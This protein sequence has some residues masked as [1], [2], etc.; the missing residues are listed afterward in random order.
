MNFIIIKKS[1]KIMVIMWKSAINK[2]LACSKIVYQMYILYINLYHSTFCT[3]TTQ[4]FPILLSTESLAGSRKIFLQCQSIIKAEMC[5]S[6]RAIWILIFLH[7]VLFKCQKRRL[8]D[9]PT[10][11]WKCS[12]VKLWVLNSRLP[13]KTLASITGLQFHRFSTFLLINNL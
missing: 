1:C 5:R 2:C 7:T 11:K 10:H 13:D 4:A 6:R 3:C 12:R 9:Q 8:T